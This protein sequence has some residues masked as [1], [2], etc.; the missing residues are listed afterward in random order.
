MEG[1]IDFVIPWVNGND[2]AWESEL[3]EY[4]KQYTPPALADVK[5]EES[6]DASEFVDASA[7]RYRDW[8]TLRY[9]FRGIEKFAP[10]VNRIHLLT[11]GHIPEWLNTSHP[12]LHIVSHKEFIPA[13]YLP[14]FSS[15]P[16]ELNMHRIE[17]LTDRFV[18]FNDDMFLCRPATPERF[19]RN[20]M[21]R[22]MAR[23][24][25][26]R[27][28][29]T[30]HNILEC[31]RVINRR[32]AK[33]EAIGNNPGKWFNRHYPIGDMVKTATLLPW[34]FFPGFKEF[35]M[36]QPF[37][38]ETFDQMWREEYAELDA[39]C[40]HQFRLPTDLSQWVMRY[41]QLASARFDPI[42][43]GDTLLTK[44]SD[45]NNETIA[46]ALQSGRYTMLCINDSN[47]IRDLE[48]ARKALLEAFENLLPEKSTYEI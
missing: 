30:D 4:R 2:P 3:R 26:I 20:G 37:L 6:P 21:P 32:Y 39:T 42:G 18:Y 29:R 12:K 9:W 10:W 23:L 11:W 45:D 5:K 27:D 38:K 34:S 24:N 16:I 43:M 15:C 28:E 35:H 17:G 22:D 33:R 48:A 13:N 25:V 1:K 14:T 40:R 7:E 41:E 47:D 19:F 46:A 44:L 31:M 8:D 36:P